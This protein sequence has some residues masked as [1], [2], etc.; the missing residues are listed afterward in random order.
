V[1]A[2]ARVRAIRAWMKGLVEDERG[3]LS[4]V[5]GQPAYGMT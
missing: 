4:P 3:R 2:T 5:D 1:A